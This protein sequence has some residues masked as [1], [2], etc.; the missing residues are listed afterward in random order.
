ML[1]KALITLLSLNDEIKMPNKTRG[2]LIIGI[3]TNKSIQTFVGSV[4]LLTRIPAK[5]IPTRQSKFNTS[6]IMIISI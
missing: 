3:R 6:K 1:A 5:P 2:K 4:R